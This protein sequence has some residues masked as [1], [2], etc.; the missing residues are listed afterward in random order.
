[1][2]IDI[3]IKFFN[4]FLQ[5]LLA[6][7][8]LGTLIVTIKLATKN[9]YQPFIEAKHQQILNDILFP[10]YESI[11]LQL[12]KPIT[13]EN[14]TL[15]LQQINR[16]IQ[17]MRSHHLF[18]LLGSNLTNCL[19]II[20]KNYIKRANSDLKTLNDYYYAFSNDYFKLSWS[21]RKNLKIETNEYH[22]RKRLYHLTTA[23]HA[24]YKLHPKQLF[25]I[26]GLLSFFSV[27]ICFMLWSLTSF[28]VDMKK[29]LTALLIAG[30]MIGFMF[31]IMSLLTSPL[32]KWIF[33]Y[34]KKRTKGITKSN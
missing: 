28:S 6:F 22:Y 7:T 9:Q 15:K 19:L 5:H 24:F 26:A 32:L 27:Y 23:E 16:F 30:A 3:F 29:K 14:K 2:D 4:W 1:M 34:F 33:Y 25:P 21:V 18:Y 17:H 11:E 31:Y 20:E 13:K 10:F 8:N 12:F